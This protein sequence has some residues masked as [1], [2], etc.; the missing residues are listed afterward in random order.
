VA[1]QNFDIDVVTYLMVIA[2]VGLAVLMPAAGELGKRSQAAA[3]KVV[4]PA[5]K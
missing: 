4:A 3:V 1:G 5:A 2:V